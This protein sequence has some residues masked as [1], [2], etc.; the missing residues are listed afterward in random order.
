MTLQAQNLTSKAYGKHCDKGKCDWISYE[1]SQKRGKD[2]ATDQP[3]AAGSSGEMQAEKWR[4]GNENPCGHA[5]S[6]LVWL[7]WQA[8]QPMQDIS[9]RPAPT[10]GR[11][12]DIAGHLAVTAWLAPF[13]HLTIRSFACTSRNR[14]EV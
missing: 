13:E 11:V 10:A 7:V 2:V 5:T 8:T 1:S 4:K 9:R 3:C 12:N 14:K 6:D